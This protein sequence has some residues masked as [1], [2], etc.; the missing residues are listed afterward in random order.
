MRVTEYQ[1]Y[2]CKAGKCPY[3]NREAMECC[4]KDNE[5]CPVE[6]K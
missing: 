4:K 3:Y 5:T 6:E 1:L 2:H